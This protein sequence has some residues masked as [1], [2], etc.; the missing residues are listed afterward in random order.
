MDTAKVRNPA[1]ASI[2]PDM[3]LRTNPLLPALMMAGLTT[4]TAAEPTTIPLWPGNAPGEKVVLLPET[5][6]TQPNENPAGRPIVIVSNVSSPAITIYQPDPAKSTGAAVLVCPGGGYNILAWDLE[7]TEVCTWLNSIGVTGVLLKY[8]VPRREGLEKH[9]APLQDAQRALGIARSRAA[10]L[11][12]DPARIGVLGFSAG[13]HLAATLSNNSLSR[14]YP[15]IDK[16]DKAG[17]RPDFCVL[18]YPAYLTMQEKNDVLAPEL[19]VH[20]TNTPP[21]FI[22]MTA[23][24]PLSM[25]PALSYFQALQHAKVLA[26][27]HVYPTGGHGY[28]LRRTT[29]A[30][31]TWPDRVTDWLT[32]SGWLTPAK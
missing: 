19:P 27:L 21:T 14:T 31:T 9:A 23:D 13:G 18:I 8:R 28:G 22:A 1:A 10:E 5:A 32:A 16:A 29:A 26:E 4:L 7:G 3:Q 30:V 12:F 15:V 2:I 6:T 11:G 25:E 20:A 17:C 24:D